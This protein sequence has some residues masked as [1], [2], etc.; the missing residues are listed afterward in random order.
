MSDAP[1]LDLDA[2]RAARA[3][4]RGDPPTVVLAGETFTLPPEM[5]MR[6]MWTLLDGDDMAALKVLF[7]GQLDRFLACDLT[8][9]DLLALLDGV[10]HLYGLRPGELSASDGSSSGTSSH[11]RPTSPATTRSTSA[12][13]ATGKRASSA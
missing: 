6:Y 7:D 2:A 11:S 3:E 10:P 9:E 4:T 13:R 8:R 12:K 5:P 1:S